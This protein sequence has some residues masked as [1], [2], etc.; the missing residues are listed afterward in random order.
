MSFRFGKTAVRVHPLLLLLWSASFL[1][2][3]PGAFLGCF[4]ALFLH[5][6]GHWLAARCLKTPMLAIELSPLGGF[7]TLENAESLPCFH[8]VLLSAAGPVFSLLGCFLAAQARTLHVD[9]LFTQSFA[10]ASLLLFL[11]NLLPAL[12]LDGGNIARHLLSRFFPRQQVSRWLSILSYLISFLFCCLSFYFAFQGMLILAPLTAGLYL[13]Y[14]ARQE[15]KQGAGWYITALIARREKLDA[16]RALPVE[17]VAVS[18]RMP[19]IRILPL[20]HAG[21]YHFLHVLSPDGLRPLAT[22]DEQTFLEMLL[23]HPDALIGEHLNEG[24]VHS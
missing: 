18:A 14:A 20:L 4:F 3:Q 10:R 8:G 15:Q 13:M 12:P 16:M 17:S 1:L 6:C 21:K 2:G 24:Q 23:S 11:L 22:L 9:P 7:M 19:L 5:E